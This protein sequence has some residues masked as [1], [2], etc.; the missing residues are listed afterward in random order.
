MNVK[1]QLSEQKLIGLSLQKEIEDSS[2]NLTATLKYL[3]LPIQE[4]RNV[5]LKVK[6]SNDQVVLKALAINVTLMDLLAIIIF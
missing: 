1:D 2:L 4:V 6:A 5:I 3:R